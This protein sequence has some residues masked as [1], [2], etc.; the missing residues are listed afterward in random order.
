MLSGPLENLCG[1]A[2][3]PAP[4]WERRLVHVTFCSLAPRPLSGQMLFLCLLRSFPFPPQSAL[5]GPSHSNTKHL[6]WAPKIH[7]EVYSFKFIWQTIKSVSLEPYE[8][9]VKL[10][11][12]KPVT[13]FKIP[14]FISPTSKQ[15][16]FTC[17]LILIWPYEINQLLAAGSLDGRPKAGTI[18]SAHRLFRKWSQDKNLSQ[19]FTG[20]VWL[21]FKFLFLES[22][23][24]YSHTHGWVCVCVCMHTHIYT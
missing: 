4:R 11:S 7:Y 22:L 2:R 21:I 6:H 24:I 10:I 23:Y 12:I 18:S 8:K 17:C 15:F 19:P 13:T 14:L 5:F 1:Q 20:K 3:Q 9:S 16:Y